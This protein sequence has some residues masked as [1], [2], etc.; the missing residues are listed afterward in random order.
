M[1][2]EKTTEKQDPIALLNK[3]LDLCDKI[4]ETNAEIEHL[5]QEYQVSTIV[6]IFSFFS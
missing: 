3:A 2:E 1:E 5:K 4:K 6:N